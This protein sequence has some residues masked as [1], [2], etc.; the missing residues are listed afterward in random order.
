MVA[1]F[2]EAPEEVEKALTAVLGERFSTWWCRATGREWRPSS[3][4]SA[5]RR[6]G[7]ASS[8]R[9]FE[10]RNCAAAPA[11]AGPDV[12][13][14]LLGLVRVK[15]GYRDVA[16]YLLGDVSVVRD[17]ESGLGLWR[18]NG[19]S[20]SLV[21]LDGEVIDP[22]GVVTGGSV[23]SLQGGPIFRRRRI[24]EL[25][26]EVACGEEGVRRHCEGV[27]E[28]RA[29]L[30][31]MDAERRRLGQELQGLAVK[32]V[33]REQELLRTDQAL[34]R[35]ER[36]LATVAQE[37]RNVADEAHTLN[38]AIAAC[39]TALVESAR[40]DEASQSR[41]REIQ[42]ALRAAVEELARC[43]RSFDR[44]SRERGRGEGAGGKR[45]VEPRQPGRP[46][47]RPRGATPRNAKR[48]SPK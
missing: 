6:G 13:A 37:L 46:A 31:G 40:E 45:Q 26:E 30:E 47:R 41:L 12:I 4:S 42:E 27:A 14:P 2:I 44:V 21:T 10:R 35:S 22:M 9:R 48:A 25:H 5:N 39:E 24:K 23:E 3:T 1:D 7:A 20:H 43:R 38:E 36:D 33:Q 29:A 16:D 15:D 17:L 18:A 19:F 11:P 8:P 32:K 28:K 34:T